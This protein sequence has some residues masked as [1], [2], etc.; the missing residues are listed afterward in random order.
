[1]THSPFKESV[2]ASY[3]AAE[4]PRFEG[5]PLILALPPIPSPAELRDWVGRYPTFT[6]ELRQ[7][8]T[9]LR[10]HCLDTIPLLVVPAAE[11]L[12]LGLKLSRLITSGYMLRN[13]I[14]IDAHARLSAVL[15]RFANGDPAPPSPAARH[16]TTGLAVVGTSGV[17]KTTCLDLLLSYYPQVIV[18]S[19]WDGTPLPLKQLVW[20][21]LQCPQD[22]SLKSLCH[23]FF[24]EVDRLLG[25]RYGGLYAVNKCRLD[26]MIEGM[27]SA[28]AVH[29]LGVLV[30]D[31]IQQLNGARAGGAEHIMNFFVRL[32]NEVGAPLVLIGTPGALPLL[33]RSLQQARRVSSIGDFAW[34]RMMKGPTWDSFLRR[35]WTYQYTREEADL[36]PKISEEMHRESQGIA[37]VAVKLFLLAQLR[38]MESAVELLSVD[39]IKSVAKD[40]LGMLA[41][42]LRALRENH[43]G[44]LQKYGDLR[45]DV[46]KQFA[47]AIERLDLAAL[48]LPEEGEIV[49]GL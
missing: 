11:H 22:G 24:L 16:S 48:P 44:N 29:R 30:I 19:E 23:S 49:V 39:L 3:R 18:H 14:A 40:E 36:T 13:P 38:A 27:V 47:T 26:D 21:K 7:L 35:L 45:W 8:P 34:S 46:S 31:E 1:M 12:Q 2:A 20:V 37:D 32:V 33:Q 25:T 43:S 10:A 4:I 42:L 28:A 41:P 17:G 15:T 5:N 9:Y 6:P